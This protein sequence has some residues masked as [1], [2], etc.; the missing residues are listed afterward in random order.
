[1][2]ELCRDALAHKVVEG[3]A[4]KIGLPDFLRVFF[5]FTKKVFDD[6]L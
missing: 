3:F 2:I 6:V 1:M 4:E 5:K